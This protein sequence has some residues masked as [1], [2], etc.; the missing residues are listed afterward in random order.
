LRVV[1]P[2]DP[3]EAAQ[4]ERLLAH[5]DDPD[6]VQFRQRSTKDDRAVIGDVLGGA[7]IASQ[8]LVAE[9]LDPDVTD[10]W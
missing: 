5:A 6:V 10:L 3:L 7:D 1:D 4:R 9:F 2:V 8:I